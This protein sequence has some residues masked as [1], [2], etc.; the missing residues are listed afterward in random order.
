[1]NSN[2]DSTGDSNINS[3]S[4]EGEECLW[5]FAIG[6][7][8]NPISMK[9]RSLHP[10]ESHPALLSE[11]RLYFFGK[12]GVAEAIPDVNSSFHGV[13]HKMTE[14]EMQQLDKIE[15]DYQRTKATATMYSKADPEVDKGTK[16]ETITVYVYTRPEI[17]DRNPTI[18]FPPSERYI[19]IMVDGCR[20]YGVAES[21]IHY[22]E[23]HDSQP[24]TKPCDFLKIGRVPADLHDLTSFSYDDI[25][26][27]V[28]ADNRCVVTMNGR[29]LEF[30]P[31]LPE[32]EAAWNEFRDVTLKFGVRGEWQLASLVYDPYYGQPCA[33][34]DITRE[35]SGALEDTM[36]RYLETTKMIQHWHTIGKYKDQV[37]KEE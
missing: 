19:Q 33:F 2:G 27:M 7:M 25:H 5:Y 31:P 1:M 3:Q 28:Y 14:R 16:G 8:M 32:A 9:N 34:S 4:E 10:R 23:Q 12:I 24:R 6:S 11:H 13:V 35:H 36:C 29:V 26:K 30:L 17:T 37:Y 18:D 22:L 15:R 20:H 21:H